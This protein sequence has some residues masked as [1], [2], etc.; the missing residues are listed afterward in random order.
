MDAHIHA[1]ADGT[2]LFDADTVPRIDHAWF[3]PVYWE[4][5]GALQ[6]RG[7]GRASASFIDTPAGE[8]V[9]R[10]Y[11]RGGM[12]A[13]LLGDHYLWTGRE[14][15]RCFA[16]FRLLA[17]MRDMGLPVP[18]PVAA[19]YCR[20]GM[21][22]SADLITRRIDDA[23]TLAQCLHADSMDADMAHQCGE[24]VARFHRNGVWHADLNAHN[25]LVTPDAMFMIDFDRGRLRQPARAWREANLARLRRSLTKLGASNGDEEIFEK[26]LWT[27]LMQGYAQTMGQL[28]E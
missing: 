2:I 3:D 11:H 12:V 17:R 5:A 20:H 10:H 24:L 26:H 23:R 19:R 14:N 22:Y 21:H 28:H 15:T 27:P 25:L 6:G 4:R 18:E 1:N 8:C 9:L 16:E 13:N 7:G